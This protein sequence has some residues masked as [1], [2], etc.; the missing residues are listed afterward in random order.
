[1][2]LDFTK[3]SCVVSEY[4]KLLMN[5]KK[6]HQLKAVHLYSLEIF[7]LTKRT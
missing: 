7:I 1:M 6:T 2:G 4:Q 3:Q 5:V